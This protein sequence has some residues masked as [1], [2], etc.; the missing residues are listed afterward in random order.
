M[1]AGAAAAQWALL[2]AAALFVAGCGGRPSAIGTP[3]AGPRADLSWTP[4]QPV[5]LR[6]LMFELRTFDGD[7]RPLDIEA[8]KGTAAMPEMSHET[9]PLPL[10][11]I[12]AGRYT[13]I[14]TFSMDGAWRFTFEGT[15]SGRPVTVH[16]DVPVGR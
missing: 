1:M 16:V 15:A 2:V 5:A 6:P 8:V 4:R 13:G 7:G 10:G 12:G 14:Y 11:R 3:G 9:E